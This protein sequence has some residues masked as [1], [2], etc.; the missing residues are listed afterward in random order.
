MRTCPGTTGLRLTKAKDKGDVAKTSLELI[1]QGPKAYPA[2]VR[3]KKRGKS[4]AVFQRK[5]ISK[6]K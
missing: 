6:F 2:C 1:G 4:V 3:E 5:G